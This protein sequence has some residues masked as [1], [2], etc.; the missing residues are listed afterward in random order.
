MVEE[1]TQLD[2]PLMKESNVYNVHKCIHVTQ[3]ISIQVVLAGGFAFDLLDRITGG[4]LNVRFCLFHFF[5]PH[6]SNVPAKTQQLACFCPNPPLFLI[7]RSLDA[8]TDT[9]HTHIQHAYKYAYGVYVYIRIHTYTP[10][11]SVCGLFEPCV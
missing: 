6:G 5:F 10:L 2:Y 3:A 1:K 4:T 7:H 9:L 8:Y 11:E